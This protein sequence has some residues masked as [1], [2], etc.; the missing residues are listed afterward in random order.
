MTLVQADRLGAASSPETLRRAFSLYPTGVTAVCAMVDGE[1]V[2]MA[3]NSFTSISLDPPLA[4]VSIANSST[5]WPKLKS[6]TS[7][8]I[9]VL[10]K[11][12]N[13]MCRQLSSRSTSRFEGVDLRTT[14]AGA[15][16]IEGAAL[17]LE[18]RYWETFDGGDHVVELLKIERCEDFPEVVPLV[19]YLSQFHDLALPT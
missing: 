8:G 11:D 16:L 18:C 6:A 3:I 1:P 10:S 12:Q 19:F 13:A 14:E 7:L 5:T 2:G 17:W 4:A 9:S 15:V